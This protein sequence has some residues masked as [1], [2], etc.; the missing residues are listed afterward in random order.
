MDEIDRVIREAEEDFHTRLDLEAALEA[1]KDDR[2]KGW[3]IVVVNQEGNGIGHAFNVR[4][5]KEGLLLLG[6][7][8]MLQHKVE[9]R[10]QEDAE[11]ED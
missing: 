4:T 6:G 11:R 7:L 3:A 8:S 10:I 1:T 5:G 2:V 9:H